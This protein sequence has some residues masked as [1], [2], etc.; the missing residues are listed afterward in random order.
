MRS[1]RANLESIELRSSRRGFFRGWMRGWRR[2]SRDLGC[3]ALEAF[4]QSRKSGGAAALSPP[5]SDLLGVLRQGLLQ[6]KRWKEIAAAYQGAIDPQI[7]GQVLKNVWD[8]RLACCVFFWARREKQCVHTLWSYQCFLEALL[9]SRGG[10][11]VIRHYV[12]MVKAGIGHDE[13]GFCLAL[14]GICETGSWFQ[15]FKKLKNRTIFGKPLSSSMFNVVLEG[16]CKRERLRGAADILRY[17][18]SVAMVSP[19]VLSY[20]IVIEAFGAGHWIQQVETC[21]RD[22]VERGIEPDAGIYEALVDAY[23]GVYRQEEACK[24]FSSMLE[25]GW[26]PSSD[27]Y[28]VLLRCC[29]KNW[30]GVS[31]YKLFREMEGVG[32]ELTGTLY[33]EMIHGFVNSRM[34]SEARA[35]TKEMVSKGFK[36]S[37]SGYSAL[38]LAFASP[39]RVNESWEVFQELLQQCG[40]VLDRETY[41][42]FVTK[43]AK[44]D[45]A[46]EAVRAYEGMTESCDRRPDEK[47]LQELVGCLCRTGSVDLAQWLINQVVHEFKNIVPSVETFNM[48]LSEY[49]CFGPS[50]GNLRSL[51]IKKAMEL[52]DEMVKLGRRP[53][54]NSFQI[55]VH[56]LCKAG[57]AFDAYKLFLTI[58]DFDLA[59]DAA[60]SKTVIMG[61]C[62]IG[63]IVEAELVFDHLLSDRREVKESS[64]VVSQVYKVIVD[65]RCSDSRKLQRKGRR[66]WNESSVSL[67]IDFTEN[68]CLGW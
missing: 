38:I 17:M 27:A 47:T 54:V 32:Y 24:A 64:L 63:R 28:S 4:P 51:E 49:C 36:P 31:G 58:R 22:M 48:V 34:F 50:Y 25:R 26:R 2:W 5:A 19:D 23:S 46:A 57:R 30:D 20:R 55:A 44:M 68:S 13:Y 45:R 37:P 67:E 65:A 12:E 41:S 66:W 42:A 18:T 35:L 16:A 15:A 53:T 62:S 39:A 60:T 11:L 6:G 21:F 9:R 59:P 56:G 61:L 8:I 10:S 14:A 43:L 52:L 1:S 7:A 40:N 33:Q 3:V 29:L